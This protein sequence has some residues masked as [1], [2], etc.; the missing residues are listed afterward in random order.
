MYCTVALNTRAATIWHL[1]NWRYSGHDSGRILKRIKTSGSHLAPENT[2]CTSYMYRLQRSPVHNHMHPKSVNPFTPS[3]S[4][5]LKP[6]FLVGDAR[7]KRPRHRLRRLV[8]TVQQAGPFSGRYL[9]AS[10]AMPS[11]RLRR[12]RRALNPPP[13]PSAHGRCSITPAL[14]HAPPHLPDA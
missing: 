6:T 2:V 7:R 8:L 3:C 13:A 11:A 9:P 4:P 10:S 12:M 14:V 1:H 5:P